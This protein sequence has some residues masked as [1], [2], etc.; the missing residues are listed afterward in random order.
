MS[1][2]LGVKIILYDTPPLNGDYYTDLVQASAALPV[3]QGNLRARFK[4][5]SCCSFKRSE[6]VAN[7]FFRKHN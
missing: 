5:L 6:S 7:V 2:G 1:G 4:R 3:M